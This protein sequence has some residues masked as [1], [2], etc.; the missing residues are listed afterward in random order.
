[1]KKKA[2]L[3]TLMLFFVSLLIPV[4]ATAD[5]NYGTRTLNQGSSGSDVAQLQQYLFDLKYL[6]HTPT[7]FYSSDTRDAVREFQRANSIR[8]NNGFANV[9]TQQAI[10]LVWTSSF[11]NSAPLPTEPKPEPTPAPEPTPTPEPVPAPEPEP[12]PTPE[13]VPAP[14]SNKIILGYYTVD[15]PGDKISYNSL[16][17]YGDHFN[18]MST[19]S[20]RV[21]G[22]GN[23]HGTAPTDGLALAKSKGIQSY[24]LIHN[25]V[26]PTGFDMDIASN[27]LSRPSARQNLINQLKQILPAHGYA[28]V[29][30]DLEYIRATERPNY[31]Q[32]IK[33]LK[34]EL[35]PLGYTVIVSVTGK[36]FDDKTSPWGGVFDFP[37]L[38]KYADYVQI[39]TY[40]EHWFGGTPGPVA[41][42]G[43]VERA[44][45]YAVSTIPSEKILLGIAAYGYDWYGSNTKVV[46]YHS[47]PKLLDQYNITPS[48]DNTAKS[49]FFH[50]TD[51]R[52]IRH[53]VWYENPR[54]M[55]YKLALVDKH[56]LGGI[57]IWRLGFEDQS[58]WDEVDKFMKK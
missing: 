51:E 32:F 31:T 28:G 29:N 20:Y 44:V 4:M 49:P 38:G 40:D 8:P 30:V 42:I 46:N 6:A 24:A 25:Y 43:Y 52:G 17:S 23:L 57:G 55:A 26:Y 15:Y 54:S 19:F 3:V 16:A 33:E 2:T 36:T 56:D 37:A 45:N 22:Q 35:G 18:A 53:E 47:V 14:Q 21:D 5:S 7:G 48:W 39:M 58:F 13:P 50:Y 41:S 1:M 9:Q 27:L 11:G 12:T 10:Q 34:E